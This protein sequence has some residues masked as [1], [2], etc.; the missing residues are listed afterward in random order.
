M[1]RIY[2]S[3]C[4]PDFQGLV[5]RL[6]RELHPQLTLDWNTKPVEKPQPD[7]AGVLLLK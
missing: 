5:K 3:Q 7:R 6:K 1:K 4:S 2:L